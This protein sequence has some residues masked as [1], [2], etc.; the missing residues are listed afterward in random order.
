MSE[1]KKAVAE[2]IVR[3]WLDASAL[4]A[5]NRDFDGHFALISKKVRV[6]GMP[7]FESI[8][9][10]DW[11]RASKKDFE[12]KVLD[13]VSYEGLK[14]SAHNDSQIMFKTLESVYVNDGTKK[15]HGVEILLQREEDDIWR[16]IQERIMTGDEIRHV[17]LM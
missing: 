1:E 13:S 14:M 2:V 16:V 10:D 11:A 17:G 8:S 15:T 7:G 3:K 9:Y 5:T 6:T 4:T 12:D